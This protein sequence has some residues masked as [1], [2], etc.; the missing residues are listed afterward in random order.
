MTMKLT[1]GMLR[2]GCAL[3]LFGAGFALAARTGFRDSP[4]SLKASMPLS[5]PDKWN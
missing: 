2:A 4:L 3:W 1:T 5:S